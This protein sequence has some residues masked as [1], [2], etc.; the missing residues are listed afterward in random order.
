MDIKFKTGLL[1]VEEDSISLQW[2][3]NSV[4]MYRWQIGQVDIIT[5]KELQHKAYVYG[6][7]LGLLGIGLMIL[8]FILQSHLFEWLSAISTIT[9]C[10]I[11]F[12]D[13]I[14]GLFG[15]NI[16]HD[17]LLIILG[18]EVTQVRVQNT[19]GQNIEFYI[20][21]NEIS[22]AKSIAD[23]RIEKQEIKNQNNEP[24]QN[25]D[26]FEQL[27]KLHGLMEKGIITES[28]FQKKKEELLK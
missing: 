9:G 10:L 18:Q 1:K 20:L 21:K 28:E 13:L 17:T 11:V 22:K 12:G 4:S 25:S 8:T 14:L 3:G 7:R 24:I 23:L 5:S 6:F 15:V 19:S 27:E 26:S 16:V 2:N